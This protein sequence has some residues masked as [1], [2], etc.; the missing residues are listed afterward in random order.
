MTNVTF[1]GLTR[2]DEP[3]LWEMLYHALYVAEG[4]Q[5]FPRSIIADPMI[6]RYVEG[7]GRSADY[8]LIAIDTG[9]EQ[10]VGAAWIRMLAR[11][12]AGYGYVDEQ[13]PEL[14]IAVFP[15]HR[16]RGIGTELLCRVLDGT[17]DRR[18]AI[19]LSDRRGFRGC[20][21]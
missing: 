17:R 11:E 20:L 14:S 19:S 7:W 1:R 18:E 9:D 6:R 5:P 15:A 12:Q 8:G 16:G 2:A 13:T 21:S 4:S 10:P 3:F